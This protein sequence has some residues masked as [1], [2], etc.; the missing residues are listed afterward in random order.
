MGQPAALLVPPL[1]VCPRASSW[2]LL[3]ST[4]PPPRLKRG[5]PARQRQNE[6][7]S[8]R[9]VPRAAR[10]SPSRAARTALFS[11][12]CWVEASAV[13][14]KDR[15][16]FVAAAARCALCCGAAHGG[17]QPTL[18]TSQPSVVLCALSPWR[19]ALVCLVLLL[20]LSPPANWLAASCPSR[21]LRQSPRCALFPSSRIARSARSCSCAVA[22]VWRDT[23]A[24]TLLL[25]APRFVLVLPRSLYLHHPV[26][27]SSTTSRENLARGPLLPQNADPQRQARLMSRKARPA[28]A[29]H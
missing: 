21:Q 7:S 22:S 26:M 9:A 3:P 14:S 19:L 1:P 24:H 18:H 2:P 15:P 10:Y 29:G 16:P 4:P 6:A 23:P 13:R 27:P 12:L 25:L 28:A 5:D 17:R 20:R 11:V 8:G